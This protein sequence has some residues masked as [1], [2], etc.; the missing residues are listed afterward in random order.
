[1]NGRLR[2][3]PDFTAVH[4]KAGAASPS[5]AR[6]RATEVVNAALSRKPS[7]H[8]RAGN[9]RRATRA[10]RNRKAEAMQIDDCGDHT[11]T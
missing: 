7:I 6:V 1:M 3:D 2:L 11:Q 10:G 4:L 8:V 5:R 9:F